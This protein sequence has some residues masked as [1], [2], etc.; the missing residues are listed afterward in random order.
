MKTYT[1][2]LNQ[3][4]YFSRDFKYIEKWRDDNNIDIVFFEG[5]EIELPSNAKKIATGV[6]AV[7]D[8]W[9]TLETDIEY[10]EPDPFDYHANDLHDT[11]RF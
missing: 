11:W 10:Q 6:F 1:T 5:N 9:K 4:I 3:A 2:T 7:C 8:R